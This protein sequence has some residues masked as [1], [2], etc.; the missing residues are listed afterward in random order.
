MRYPT[1]RTEPLLRNWLRGFEDFDRTFEKF[2]P[3]GWKEGGWNAMLKP[4]IDV[5]ETEN[6]YLMTVDLPGV[7]KDAVK[8][9]AINNEI[10]VSGERK[11]ERSD[12]SKRYS[13][14]I[15]GSFQRVLTVPADGDLSRVN[16]SYKDGVL[17]VVIPKQES[18][19]P[20]RVEISA[21]G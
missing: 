14:K 20:R 21:K 15:Y 16:A 8:I 17:E 19:K 4:A 2:F 6:Q 18:S 3:D 12:K 5:H 13:E 1:L 11:E 9:E 10:V 7:P